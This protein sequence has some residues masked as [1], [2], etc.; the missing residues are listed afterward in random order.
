[1][2]ASLEKDKP[3]DREKLQFSTQQLPSFQRNS[4]KNMLQTFENKLEPVFQTHT[5]TVEYLK[6][7]FRENWRQNQ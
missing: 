3:G 6:K 5:T 1:M 2:S 7:R 4:W